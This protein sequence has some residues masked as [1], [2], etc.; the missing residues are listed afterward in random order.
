MRNERPVGTEG[1]NEQEEV[2]DF[3]STAPNVS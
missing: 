2:L 1:W 3:V